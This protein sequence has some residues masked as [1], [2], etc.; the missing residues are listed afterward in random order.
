MYTVYLGLY[1]FFSFTGN[2]TYEALKSMLGKPQKQLEAAPLLSRSLQSSLERPW[3]GPHN[4]Q[5]PSLTLSSTS[6]SSQHLRRLPPL[7]LCYLHPHLHWQ[8]TPGWHH[9]LAVGTTA[10]QTTATWSPRRVSLITF[11]SSLHISKIS[12][13]L[14][15]LGEMDLEFPILSLLLYTL[16]DR[17]L[18]PILS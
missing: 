8:K 17:G 2:S 18:A 12:D 1:L 6:L 13:Q 9:M 16:L 5:I 3:A 7:D 4:N 11:R 15:S 14:P 10:A